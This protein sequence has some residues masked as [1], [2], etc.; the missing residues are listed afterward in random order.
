MMHNYFRISRI[1]VDLP[2]SLIGKYLYFYDLR[3]IQI[4]KQLVGLK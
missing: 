2:Y 1:V 4:Y 3:L